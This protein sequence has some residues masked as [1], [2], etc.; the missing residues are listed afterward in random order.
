MRRIQRED[1]ATARLVFNFNETTTLRIEITS[2]NT[3][4]GRTMWDPDPESLCIELKYWKDGQ[5]ETCFRLN[6]PDNKWFD[7]APIMFQNSRLLKKVINC[8]IWNTWM[9]GN[10]DRKPFVTVYI[11]PCFPRYFPRIKWLPKL[12]TEMEIPGIALRKCCTHRSDCFDQVNQ[13]RTRLQAI[14]APEMAASFHVHAAVMMM[15]ERERERS[16]F[17]PQSVRRTTSSVTRSIK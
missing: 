16:Y 4:R 3:A 10:L 8:S 15:R 13:K 17:P 6:P 7:A 12:T 9:D 5:T 14:R 2:A 11:G 1:G